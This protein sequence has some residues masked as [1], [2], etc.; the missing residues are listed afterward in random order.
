[1]SRF[2]IGLC[3]YTGNSLTKVTNVHFPKWQMFVKGELHPCFLNYH[4]LKIFKISYVIVPTVMVIRSQLVENLTE[5]NI[6]KTFFSYFLPCG[7]QV[8]SDLW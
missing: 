6:K 4:Y 2:S 7:K 5:Q 1:M 3:P 8:I